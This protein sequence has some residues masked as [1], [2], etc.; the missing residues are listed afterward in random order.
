MRCPDDLLAASVRRPLSDVEGQALEIHLRNCEACRAAGAL[1]ALLAQA[2]ADEPRHAALVSRLATALAAKHGVGPTPSGHAAIGGRAWRD[3][4]RVRRVAAVATALVV[5]SGTAVAAAWMTIAAVRERT[6]PEIVPLGEAPRPAPA[7]RRAARRTGEG[8]SAPGEAPAVASLASEGE[9]GGEVER[10]RAPA[11]AVDPPA[12][13]IVS[14]PAARSGEAAPRSRG[15]GAAPPT[16]GELFAGAN[17]LRRRGEVA[18]AIATYRALV[19]AYPESDESCVASL[20]LGEL[21]LRRREPAAAEAEFARYLAKRPSGALAEEALY[22][23]ARAL[24]SLGRTDDER[25]AWRELERRFPASLYRTARR[26]GRTD[27]GVHPN[28]APDTN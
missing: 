21:L 25:Q 24:R 2:P 16:A 1:T 12:P 5:V 26:G 17:S 11:A 6:S 28:A 20:S 8:A 9:G 27:D 13:G 19:A 23:R 3:R 22:G 4:G 14:R 10:S 7:A 18:E 15:T